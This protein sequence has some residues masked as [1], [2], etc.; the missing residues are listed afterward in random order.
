MQYIPLSEARL[1]ALCLLWNEVIGSSFPMT[2]RL[3]RQNSLHDPQLFQA[4]S[5]IA[6][7]ERSNEAAGFIVAKAPQHA[8]AVA[9]PDEKRGWIQILL[10]AGEHRGSG[11]G[12][13]LLELAETGFR[14]AGIERVYLGND[15]HYR[16]FPG[17][18]ERL[19]EAAGWF[20]RRGYEKREASY[21]LLMSY[22]RDHRPATP[23][24]AGAEFR[25]LAPGEQAELIGF[26]R[27]CFPYWAWQTEDYFAR[28]GTGREFVV[29]ARDGAI[30]GFCRI[31]DPESPILT[32]NI[33]WS[34]LFAEPLGG[35]GPL[36]ID[37]AYRGF[38]YGL[39]IVQAGIHALLERG[40]R[41]IVIDTTPYV[42][43]YGK[44]GYEV[45]QSYWRYD[46][47]L[48]RPAT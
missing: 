4:G 11:I 16:Y 47:L 31:N 14:S 25:L 15:L 9:P 38:G 1:E 42:D 28:G 32:Q 17:I 35:A 5:W 3:M 29:L 24:V 39:A 10:V 26:M 19:N 21:D 37:E 23:E 46:K 13:R 22:G 20:E 8:D 48:A 12:S 18:P 33:Y 44:L 6:V 7:D 2:E 27:R 40:V 41:H 43:F 45:W 30:I 34:G 36:G